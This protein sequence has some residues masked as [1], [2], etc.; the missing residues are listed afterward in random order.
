MRCYK[1]ISDGYILAVGTGSGGT[2]ITEAEYDRILAVIRTKPA[3]TGATDYRLK[4]D[5]TWEAYEFVPVEP[6]DEPALIAPVEAGM[7]ATRNY[8]AGELLSAAGLLFRVTANVPNGGALIEGV[9]VERT[10]VSEQ[11]ALLADNT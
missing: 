8:A 10:T 3:R 7:T 1:Q 11:L 5:L 6:A 4:A 2:E 9:N